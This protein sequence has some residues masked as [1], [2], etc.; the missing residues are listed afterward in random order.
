[1]RASTTEVLHGGCQ[2]VV[3]NSHLTADSQDP[4]SRFRIVAVM[5]RHLLAAM[6]TI[7]I[8][9]AACSSGGSP[10][11]GTAAGT[12][13]TTATSEPT[14]TDQRNERLTPLSA[15]FTEGRGGEPTQSDKDAAA[16]DFRR[17]EQ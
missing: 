4:D 1:M 3:K 10:R 16:A 6:A 12:A 17:M 7:T 11:P 8:A 5:R 13:P 9:T 2:E 14:N 15:F